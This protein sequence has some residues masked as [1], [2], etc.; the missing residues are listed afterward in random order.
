MLDLVYGTQSP[1]LASTRT[2]TTTTA[3]GNDSEVTGPSAAAESPTDSAGETMLLTHE[4]A[5]KLCQALDLAQLEVELER[6]IWQVERAIKKQNA[7]L[8]TPN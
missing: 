4:M 2:S 8:E 6:A 1:P 3:L 5:I 7:E